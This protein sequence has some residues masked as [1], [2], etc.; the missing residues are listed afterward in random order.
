V[1]NRVQATKGEHDEGGLLPAFVL[2]GLWALFI[3]SPD[4]QLLDIKRAWG[5]AFEAAALTW[6]AARVW[7][8]RSVARPNRLFLLAVALLALAYGAAWAL[9]PYAQAGAF[10]MTALGL[11]LCGALLAASLPAAFIQRWYGVMLALALV[12]AAYAIAQRCGLDPLQATLTAGSRQRAIGTFGNATFLAAFLCFAWPLAF[13]LKG[14]P[15][16]WACLI[17]FLAL[18]STQSRAG[19]LAA[20]IQVAL[21]AWM[22][23]KDGWRPRGGFLFSA[24]AAL[25]ASFVVLFPRE[26]W[27]RPTLRLPL[28]AESLRLGLQRPWL[29]WGPGSFGLALQDHQSA[30]FAQALGGTQFAEHPHNWVLSVLHEAGLLGLLAFAFLLALLQPWPGAMAR[31]HPGQRALALG[32]LGLLLQNLFDRNLD[33]AGLGLCF[34]FGLGLLSYPS[35]APGRLWPR[36]VSIPLLLLAAFCVWLGL[37]PVLAYEAAVGPAPG[38]APAQGDVAALRTTA[39]QSPNDPQLWDR[40]GTALVAQS[41]FGEAADAFARAQHLQASPGRAINLGNCQLMLSRPVDAEASFRQAVQLAP[42]NADAH[43][44]LGYA[45]FYQKRLKEAV[46]ELDAALQLDP[47]HAAAAKLKEQIL[48]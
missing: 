45:L 27:L 20:T 9:S 22:A 29:G 39:A 3:L 47:G 4:T 40:L 5:F 41:A 11:G 31:R 43:F 16:S 19:L 25:L 24:F 1:A 30:A 7:L 46:A 44:S 13:L 48:R 12:V 8:R 17:F 14:R 10:R 28:W 32:L 21:Q 38:L 42:Q 37:R 36:V 15:R 18:V 34:F 35:P 33:Q 2:L 26:Q 23:W 6:L